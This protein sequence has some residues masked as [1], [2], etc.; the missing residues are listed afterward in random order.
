M[1]ME[2][3]TLANT[4][5]QELYITNTIKLAKDK[6]QRSDVREKAISSIHDLCRDGLI[7]DKDAIRVLGEI[8]EEVDPENI[9]EVG[10]IS[11]ARRMMAYIM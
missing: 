9:H 3:L 8:I 5:S 6:K 10:I 11:E 4:A 1:P 2:A 7:S